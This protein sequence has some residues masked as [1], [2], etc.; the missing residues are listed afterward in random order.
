[1]QM[2][3]ILQS[4]EEVDGIVIKSL[5]Y[6]SAKYQNC[7][8]VYDRLNLSMN[9]ATGVCGRIARSTGSGRPSVVTVD[10]ATYFAPAGMLQFRMYTILFHV[11]FEKLKNNMRVFQILLVRFELSPC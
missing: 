8:R 1:M 11:S 5:I 10:N 7:I 4:H 6:I 2:G 9:V 3:D